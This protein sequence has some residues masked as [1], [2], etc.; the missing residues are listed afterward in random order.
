MVARRGDA[1]VADTG[2]ARLEPTGAAAD[3]GQGVAAKP[4]TDDVLAELAFDEEEW[5]LIV[6]L[7]AGSGKKAKQIGERK[8]SFKTGLDEVT[9]EY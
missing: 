7:F 6:K 5:F 4:E 2:A 8:I 1:L 9:G 3:T